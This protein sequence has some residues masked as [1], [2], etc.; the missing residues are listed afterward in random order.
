MNGKLLLMFLL[1]GLMACQNDSHKTTQNESGNGEGFFGM[2]GDSDSAITVCIWDKAV[3]RTEPSLEN[4]KWISSVTLGEK[5]TWLNESYVDSANN[6]REFLKI[7]LSDGK[8]GW[9]LAYLLVRNARP[10][11]VT[12]KVYVYSRPDIL[13]ITEKAF[14]PMEMIAITKFEKDWLEVVGNQRKKSGWIKNEGISLKDADVA[15]AI[16]ASKALAEDD[17]QKKQAK[18]QAIIENPDL[19]NSVFINAIRNMLMPVPSMEE[20]MEGIQDPIETKPQTSNT[21]KAN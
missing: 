16:L 8:E 11:A 20:E 18:L 6:N 10:A 9:T 3:L 1:I 13:T 21:P 14:D 12:Q 4:G 19:E 5:V 15:V 17:I 7:R 2:G